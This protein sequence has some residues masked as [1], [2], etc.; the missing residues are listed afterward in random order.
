MQS[1]RKCADQ[2]REQA[3]KTLTPQIQALENE[4]R[5]LNELFV[6][7]IR[8]VGYKLE[9]LRNTE[10]PATEL[11]LN[12]YLDNALRKLDIDGRMLALFTRG[13]RTKETQEEILDSLLDN[14]VNCFPCVAL[15][16]VRGDIFKGWS[17]RGFS[18]STAETI[19]S[20]EFRQTGCS[21]LV[22]TL[23]NGNQ[24]KSARLPDIGSLRLMCDESP[25]AWRLYPLHVL[26]RPVAILIA[27]EAE[28]FAGRPEVMAALMD[29]AALRLENV[30]LKIIKTL[31]ESSPA[32]VGTNAFAAKTLLNNTSAHQPTVVTLPDS[33][34]IEPTAPIKTPEQAESVDTSYYEPD[35]TRQN[36]PAELKPVT[37]PLEPFVEIPAP[38]ASGHERETVVETMPNATRTAPFSQ[39]AN[40]DEILHA[41]TKRFAELLVSGIKFYNEHAIVEGRK[42]RDLYKRLQQSIIRN[43]KMYEKRVAPAVAEKIDYLH[44]ELVRILAGGDV[45]AFGDDYPGPVVGGPDRIVRF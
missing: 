25:G 18:D 24:A 4:L 36:P 34:S 30:A 9:A 15:F 20:D 6:N 10:L 13:L 1:V 37:Q 8:D 26:G 21:W 42:N 35:G 7:G 38:E 11:I 5:N 17:S 16:A 43:R 19:S 32:S 44:E 31:S 27:G 45:G 40:D 14:A 33:L 22:E 2:L 29:C 12:D 39:P 28:D 23:G 3:N 41:A